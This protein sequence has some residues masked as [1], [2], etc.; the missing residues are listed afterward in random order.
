MWNKCYGCVVVVILTTPGPALIQTVV[1]VRVWV[2]TVAATPSQCTQ[3]EQHLI[4]HHLHLAVN[5]EKR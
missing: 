4:T 2:A 3:R 1:P 5:T